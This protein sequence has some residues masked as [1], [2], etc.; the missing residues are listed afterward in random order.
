VRVGLAPYQE[1]H[2]SAFL[3]CCADAAAFAFLRKSFPDAPTPA[4]L[5]ERFLTSGGSPLSQT[6]VW[7]IV[8]ND[9]TFAGHLELKTTDKTK[10][11]EGEL[12]ALVARAFRRTGVASAAVAL[13]LRSPHLAPE[14]SS[15]L[16]VCRTTNEASL[17][18]VR[19]SGFVSLPDRSSP[20]ALF[21]GYRWSH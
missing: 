6:R 13:L 3:D 8:T 11:A 7:A 19:R 2:S 1:A 4:V 10:P 18:L 12:V 9:L 21:F 14:F 5:L 15:V 17:R 20:E 16:A